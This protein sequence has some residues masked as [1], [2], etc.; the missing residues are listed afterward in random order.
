MQGRISERALLLD[1]AHRAAD[2]LESLPE[3]PVNSRASLADLR[4]DL[5]APLPED[6]AGAEATIARLAAAADPG[7]VATAGPRYFGFVIGGSHPAALAADWL[8]SAW[9]QNAAMYVMSPAVA[10]IE[11]TAARWILE[12]LD[13]PRESS[14]GF[15]TGA[16]MATFTSL[17]AA[18]GAVLRR[19]GW[20]VDASGLQGAPHIRV[21]TSDESH[22]T[23]FAALRMLGLGSET[24][25][26]VPADGQGRMRVDEL[27]RIP[28]AERGPTIV[29]AQAGN[30]NSGAF[31]PL[32]EVAAIAHGHGAWLHVDGAFGLWAR[33]SP[34]LAALADGVDLADSWTLDAHKWLNVPYDSGVAVVR[35]PA[36]H[37]S[38]MS[39][40]AAYYV[41]SSGAERDAFDWVPESSRRARATPIWAIVNALGRS[42]VREIVERNCRLARRMVERLRSEE[43]VAILNGVVL[44]QALVR[45]DND[46]TVTRDAIARVQADGTCWLGGT[47]WHGEAAMRISV[48]N[49]STDDDDAD[50]SAEAIARCI[51]QARAA[52]PRTADMAR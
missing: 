36:A 13:L 22:A 17:A 46:D 30:V 43:G 31:D 52:A 19:H 38:A 41:E 2:F 50:R 32:R 21:I 33:V 47:T 6:G 49:W 15:T 8:S 40:G 4:R 1:T 26:R 18:R 11:E 20:D 29:C 16:T 25:V 24:A 44:N 37:H 35:D 39:Y 28:A 3:R 7:I 45:V 34:E 5:A 14:V 12:L 27:G 51:R 48:S 23:V 9:D 10:V 42:G